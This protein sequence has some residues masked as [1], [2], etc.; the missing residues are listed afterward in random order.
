MF[1]GKAKT[2]VSNLE[3]MYNIQEQRVEENQDLMQHLYGYGTE[4][5]Y[6]GNEYHSNESD[7]YVDEDEYADEHDRKHEYQG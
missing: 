1:L 4:A 3:I 6:Q 7:E 2:E 5:Q